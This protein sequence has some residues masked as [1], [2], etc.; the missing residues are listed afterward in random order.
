MKLL[1]TMGALFQTIA[2]L[3]LAKVVFA[4]GRRV[5]ATDWLLAVVGGLAALGITWGAVISE[6][7]KMGD[8]ALGVLTGLAFNLFSTFFFVSLSRKPCL[9]CLDLPKS[10]KVGPPRSRCC[11]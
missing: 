3:W 1:L 6:W 8:S 11:D 10:S 4:S 9:R 2:A 5:T 7:E